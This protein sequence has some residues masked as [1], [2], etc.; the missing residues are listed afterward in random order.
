MKYIALIS[1]LLLSSCAEI[2]ATLKEIAE[3]QDGSIRINFEDGKITKEAEIHIKS[4]EKK[5]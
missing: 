3:G 2:P 4:A 5:N 1:L